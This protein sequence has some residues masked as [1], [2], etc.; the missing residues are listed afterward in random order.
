MSVFGFL[1]TLNLPR[2]C[3]MVKISVACAGAGDG[4]PIWIALTTMLL[5]CLVIAL[6]V[7]AI[8]DL[9]EAVIPVA[10]SLLTG[11]PES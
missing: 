1:D 6:V 7:L 4:G 5:T 3:G 11:E 9:R 2:W 10:T 8:P